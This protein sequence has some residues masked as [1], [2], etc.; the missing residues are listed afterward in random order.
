M[1]RKLSRSVLRGAI[2]KVLSSD[3]NSLVAY[4]TAC[5]VREGAGYFANP[6]ISFFLVEQVPYF[7]GWIFFIQSPSFQVNKK[8]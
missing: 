3:S 1:T 8:P 2:G 5:T 6:P 7:Y 4:F